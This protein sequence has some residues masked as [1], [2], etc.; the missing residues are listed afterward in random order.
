MNREVSKQLSKLLGQVP[1]SELEESSAGLTKGWYITYP[2]AGGV[3]KKIACS[4]F[5][6]Y[7]CKNVFLFLTQKNGDKTKL[8]PEG[9]MSPKDTPLTFGRRLYNDVRNW[10]GEPKDKN[11]T[12][13]WFKHFQYHYFDKLDR[14][15]PTILLKYGTG[16][17]FDIVIWMDRSGSMENEIRDIQHNLNMLCDMIL[18][19]NPENRVAIV[20][21]GDRVDKYPNPDLDPY[22][23]EGRFP[24]DDANRRPWSYFYNEELIASRFGGLTNDRAVIAQQIDALDMTVGISADE[25]LWSIW[26]TARMTQPPGYRDERDADLQHPQPIWNKLNW[27]EDTRK[28]IIALTDE[29]MDAYIA[30]SKRYAIPF[31]PDKTPTFEDNDYQVDYSQYNSQWWNAPAKYTE[32]SNMDTDTVDN[33]GDLDTA[34]WYHAEVYLW[35]HDNGYQHE[36]GFPLSGTTSEGY[37][38]G[39][40]QIK[41][42]L[43]LSQKYYKVTCR[44][45][46]HTDWSEKFQ[47]SGGWKCP[48]CNN[49]T[50]PY[51][52]NTTI[53]F[54][55]PRKTGE[56]P[57]SYT[58]PYW[59][60]TPEE[61]FDIWAQPF[62]DSNIKVYVINTMQQTDILYSQD[63]EVNYKR[64]LTGCEAYVYAIKRDLLSRVTAGGKCMTVKPNEV[65]QTLSE[66]FTEN[67]SI[68]NKWWNTM[69]DSHLPHSETYHILPHYTTKEGRNKR[70][71]LPKSAIIPNEHG[72]ETDA[73]NFIWK[74]F[75]R[76]DYIRIVNGGWDPA[77]EEDLKWTDEDEETETNENVTDSSGV[78]HNNIG[79]V[80]QTLKSIEDFLDDLIRE[81]QITPHKGKIIFTASKEANPLGFGW[82]NV[83]TNSNQNESF[84]WSGDEQNDGENT[85][86]V[87]GIIDHEH[88]TIVQGSSK[89]NIQNV[90]VIGRPEGETVGGTAGASTVQRVA[91]NINGREADTVRPEVDTRLLLDGQIGPYTG[92]VIYSQTAGN[93]VQQPH[94]NMPM[95]YKVRAF[96]YDG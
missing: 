77:R 27:G 24:V 51:R 1:V 42:P 12:D 28:I 66:I 7:L 19:Q 35:E 56:H 62:N 96:R 47:V 23:T 41:A 61:R 83:L 13:Y 53:P 93:A 91:A 8:I 14:R 34:N 11:I 15:V 95:Y 50:V 18:R 63:P 54:E 76:R 26:K 33:P 75:N 58:S 44:G 20:Q 6:D 29:P 21:Y 57:W 80:D 39:D 45:C 94:N 92:T 30:V 67:L 32:P 38:T 25:S 43:E 17:P 22:G 55:E 48:Q 31:K 88:N 65:A 90:S 37:T 72:T 2:T 82:H 3:A 68:Y 73:A 81:L 9:F 87:P 5:Y 78:I 46:G 70:L 86:L 74:R 89:L 16:Q 69:W 79:D 59:N 40:I 64:W 71:Y 49:T 36:Q 85:N 52:Q 4:D 10:I 60:K 84:V